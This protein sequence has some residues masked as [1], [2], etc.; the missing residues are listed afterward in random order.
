MNPE[1]KAECLS[2][3]CDTDRRHGGA[4]DILRTQERKDDQ[5]NRNEQRGSSDSREHRGRRNQY[6]N[7]QHEPVES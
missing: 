3:Q 7:R 1:E 5:E 4:D 6:R 2:Q